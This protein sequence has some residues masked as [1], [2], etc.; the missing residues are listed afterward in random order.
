[1]SWRSRANSQRPS[2]KRLKINLH[3]VA[4]QSTPWSPRASWLE[5]AGSVAFYTS[6]RSVCFCCWW[7]KFDGDVQ[8]KTNISSQPFRELPLGSH[9]SLVPILDC[10]IKLGADGLRLVGHLAG[11]RAAALEGHQHGWTWRYSMNIMSKKLKMP[12][13][14][15]V[16]WTAWRHLQVTCFHV[17]LHL[18]RTL[19]PL[20][21]GRCQLQLPNTTLYIPMEGAVF[22]QC[23][24]ETWNSCGNIGNSS[25]ST[26]HWEENTS[27]VL[28]G[29]QKERFGRF[30]PR[31]LEHSPCYISI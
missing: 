31:I 26:N 7:H 29:P 4:N 24:T 13:K 21:M 27:E 30:E 3:S 23:W 28:C 6:C 15:W 17:S 18:C 9:L 2:N 10:T 25:G 1:M 12:S 19:P 8:K 22:S 5:L 11:A 20:G 14:C 16:H